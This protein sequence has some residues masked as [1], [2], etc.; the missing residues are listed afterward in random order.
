M[1]LE[2]KD[3]I[4]F[5]PKIGYTLISTEIHI[6][7]VQFRSKKLVLHGSQISQKYSKDVT[8]LQDFIFKIHGHKYF[9]RNIFLFP[10]RSLVYS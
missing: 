8:F 4:S 6:L 5:P 1:C 3:W 9:N 10:L 7:E 2:L